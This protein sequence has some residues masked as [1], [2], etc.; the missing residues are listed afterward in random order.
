MQNA[1]TGREASEEGKH[2][3]WSVADAIGA[4]LIEPDRSNRCEYQGMAAVIKSAQV[5]TRHIAITKSMF[6]A[7]EL[8]LLA[9]E[10]IPC[11]FNVYAI[12]RQVLESKKRSAASRKGRETQWSFDV[13]ALATGMPPAH[14]VNHIE[15]RI[16]L[17]WPWAH[18]ERRLRNAYA[19]WIHE[20]KAARVK[21]IPTGSQ[22]LFYETEHDYKHEGN[23]AKSIF[24]A[25]TLT[26][27]TPESPHTFP[28]HQGRQWKESRLV[29]LDRWVKPSQGVSLEQIRK[30][31]GKQSNWK[32][33][34]GPYPIRP[35]QFRALAAP[36]SKIE[37]SKSRGNEIT[38]SWQQPA[39]DFRSVTQ[40]DEANSIRLQASAEVQIRK[41]HN[42]L[43]NQFNDY[44]HSILALRPEEDLFDLLLRFPDSKTALLIEAKSAFTGC[45]GRHQ[46][47][48]AIG[49]LFDYRF[50]Y[51]GKDA[52]NVK[53]AVLLPD[54]PIEQ[55]AALLDSLD[56]GIIWRRGENFVA[57]ER[58]RSAHA[59]LQ[60]IARPSQN[61]R[62]GRS[63]T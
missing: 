41:V 21:R 36:L 6:P 42:Q 7:L 53:L 40:K 29:E 30:V 8:V 27:N 43:V 46:A 13:K 61:V 15:Y 16:E 38:G 50:T 12:P 34:S 52:A 60:K 58:V 25:G 23:G 51:W 57:T 59:L 56:I 22:I 11:Q 35:D 31:L 48:Q 2:I 19:L 18:E 20:E 62:V 45:V 33:R 4:R 10:T 14:Q 39:S 3:A 17:Y 26:D 32:M 49:Q 47:R 55:I 54:E 9:V 1:D 37:G 5:G 28:D 24:A 63:D 44:C